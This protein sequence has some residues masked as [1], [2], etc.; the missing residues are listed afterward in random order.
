[1]SKYEPDFMLLNLSDREKGV[2]KTVGEREFVSTVKFMR[3]AKIEDNEWLAMETLK[4][5]EEY[6]ARVC[7]Y[8]REAK[9]D[10]R[11]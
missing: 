5:Y 7:A 9:Y 11:I 6:Y 1:M 4:L 10:E 3:M 2:L 8:I